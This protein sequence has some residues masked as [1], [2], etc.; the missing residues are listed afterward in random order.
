MNA[1]GRQP[2]EGAYGTDRRNGCTGGQGP[3]NQVNLGLFTWL[4]PGWNEVNLGFHRVR[5]W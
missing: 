5:A 1:P 3:L 4:E 2:A